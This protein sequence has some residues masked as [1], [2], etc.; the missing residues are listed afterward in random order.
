[1]QKRKRHYCM[2]I[3]GASLVTIFGGVAVQPEGAVYRWSISDAPTSLSNQ[4]N[5]LAIAKQA[6]ARYRPIRNLFVT[7]FKFERREKWDAQATSGCNDKW[8]VS[9]RTV[10][11]IELGRAAHL[12]SGVDS[13]WI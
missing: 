3:I 8:I 7:S 10:F 9:A 2:A 6:F 1:M 4:D 12:C 13:Y 11:G 5:A